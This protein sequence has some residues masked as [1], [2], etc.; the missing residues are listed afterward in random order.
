[1]TGN[2]YCFIVNTNLWNEIQDVL[3]AWIKDYKTVG[4]FLFSKAENGYVNVGATFSSYEFAGNS[5]CFKVDRSLDIEFPNRK[6]GIFVDLTA[7]ARSGRAAM[8]M[9]TFKNG[10]Y[11]HNFIKGVN[12]SRWPLCIEI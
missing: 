12:N 3:G 6:Y 8:N 5:V 1:M 7:D 2:H 10:Q 9:F 11:I 4:T